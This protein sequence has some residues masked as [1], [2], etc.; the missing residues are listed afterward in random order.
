MRKSPQHYSIRLAKVC[1]RS[2]N[3]K[4]AEYKAT[5][6]MDHHLHQVTYH[7]HFSLYSELLLKSRFFYSLFGQLYPEFLQLWFPVVTS[8]SSL[9]L[10]YLNVA[11]KKGKN[12]DGCHNSFQSFRGCSTGA[13]V[14]VCAR[15]HVFSLKIP[16]H[17]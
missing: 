12:T 7:H 13:C 16:K 17:I 3:C 4:R 1:N 5:L 2:I 10:K 9:S 11:E 14:C 6:C 15:A 8:F